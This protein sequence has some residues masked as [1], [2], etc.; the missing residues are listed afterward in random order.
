MEQVRAL[1]TDM[2]PRSVFQDF[3]R[4]ISALEG[5]HGDRTEHDQHEQN[6]NVNEND[7]EGEQ[8]VDSAVDRYYQ[9]L[10]FDSDGNTIS[11]EDCSDFENDYEEQ[12]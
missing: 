3:T 2:V 5:V 8:D 4:R 1:R 7:N 9:G 10:Y 12:V 11:S 6:E